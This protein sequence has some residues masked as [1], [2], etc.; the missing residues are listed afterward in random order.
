[1]KSDIS[2]DYGRLDISYSRIFSSLSRLLLLSSSELK[3]N[4]IASMD[5]SHKPFFTQ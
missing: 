1:M 2:I 5:L 4:K 3:P